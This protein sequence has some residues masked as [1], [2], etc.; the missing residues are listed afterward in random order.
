LWV[1][2]PCEGFDP[3]TRNAVNARAEREKALK[4][5]AGELAPEL[6]GLKA[7]AIEKLLSN[8]IANVYGAP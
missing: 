3:E 1:V 4:E 7:A 8:A 6:V 5:I 2:G